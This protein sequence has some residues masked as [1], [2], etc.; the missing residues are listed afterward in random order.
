MNEQGGSAGLLREGK[1]STWEGG[2]REPCIFWAPGTIEPGIV[3]GIGSTMDLY[4]T[5]SLLAGVPVPDDR[6]V[7]GMD[8]S[9]VLFEGKESPR[10]EMF[11]YRGDRLFA[12]R[13]GDYKA[14]FI[15]QSGYEPQAIEHDPPLLYN[16]NVDPSEKYDIAADHPEVIEQ[17]LE[18]VRMHNETLVRGPDMLKDR[19]E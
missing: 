17:I 2:M 5:F 1:G 6:V 9:P 15:T 19:G 18:V 4:T 13:A 3:T 16:L 10:N 7:D 14:H 11:F 12:V 8:L